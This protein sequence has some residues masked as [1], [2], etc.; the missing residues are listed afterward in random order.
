MI[1]TA[2]LHVDPAH[3]AF[4]NLPGW[5]KARIYKRMGWRTR[6]IAEELEVPNNTVKL[7][8]N[9]EAHERAIANKREYRKRQQEAA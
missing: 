6:C 7:W 5:H 1:P 3:P 4:E 2:Y 8:L 9:P